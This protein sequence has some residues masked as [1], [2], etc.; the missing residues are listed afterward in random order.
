M[1][2]PALPPPPHHCV[3]E[4]LE[5]RAPAAPVIFDSP[6]SGAVYPP[7]F[8]AT[9]PR[10]LLR[11]A[12]DSYVDELI[13][14]APQQGVTVLNAMF[15]RSY[16]DPNRAVHDIDPKVV[17]GSWPGP[18]DPSDKGRLGMGLIRRLCKP[19]VPMYDRRLRVEE[20]RHRIDHYYHPYHRALRELMDS[21]TE[22]FGAVWHLNCHS[23]PS[24]GAVLATNRGWERADFVLGDRDGSTCEPAFRE[25]VAD[26]LSDL[27]YSVRL[28]DPYKGVEL[29]RRFSAP[30]RGRHSLQLEI[31]R[32]LYMDET[33]LE[34]RAPGFT[35]IQR[36]IAKLA[37]IVAAY[38]RDRLAA[39]AAD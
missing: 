29:V 13:E 25:V 3:L 32:R 1:T 27:G 23:M 16:I 21:Y 33:T 14:T 8:G 26:T 19:G 39:A 12:E 7:D 28:N 18:A 24:V 17:A 22:R 20:I 5:P 37:E 36:D 38:A 34:K 35:R 10:H 30:Q 15:P 11:Q 2:N 9:C 4:I 31:N 6:H